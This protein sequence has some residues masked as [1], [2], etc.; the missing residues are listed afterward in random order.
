MMCYE[1]DNNGLGYKLCFSFG[2]KKRLHRMLVTN[3]YSAAEF[4]VKW[5]LECFA[6]YVGYP[7]LYNIIKQIKF[8]IIP[9][10]N[11]KEYKRLWRGCPF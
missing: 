11:Q 10:K 1:D 4:E 5:K 8:Y 2:N 9:V 7:K 6:R 3:V